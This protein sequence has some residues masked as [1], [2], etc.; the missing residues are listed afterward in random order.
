[1]EN[2]VQK[3]AE[4]LNIAGLS[5]SEKLH[6]LEDSVTRLIDQSN[7]YHKR[8]DE[9]KHL[10]LLQWLSSSPFTR[11]HEAISETRMPN[12][13][14]W[15]LN[16]SRF[17]TWRDSSSSSML[18][19]HGIQGSGKSKICSAVVDAFLN[20]RASN[21][22]TA[23]VAYF[24]CADCEFEPERAEASHVM[25]SIL[26]QLTIMNTSQ[27]TVHDTLLSEFESRLAQS[28]I[29]GMDLRK[30]TV[31]DC[32]SLILEVTIRNPVTI[33]VDALDEVRETERAALTNA[34]EEIVV[35]SSSV[36]K[37]FLTSRNNSHNFSLLG[38]TNAPTQAVASHQ[39]AN[40]HLNEIEINSDATL[41]DMRA[42]VSR[43]LAQAVEYR[44]LLKQNPSLALSDLL[45]EKLLLGAGEMFQWVNA[46]IEYLC[47]H[48]REEDITAALHGGSFTSLGDT[49]MQIL[50]RILGRQTTEREIAV[51]AISWL[52]Y[53]Q[54]PILANDFVTVI[55]AQRTS[56]NAL[57]D[58]QELLTICSSLIQLDTKCNTFRF[59]HNS[60]Q[61]FLRTQEIF[62]PQSAQL[63]LALDCLKVCA[64]GPL[65][66]VEP[67]VNRLYGY[68]AVY[69]AYH[70]SKA[71]KSQDQEVLANEVISFVCDSP[72]DFSLSF[73]EWLNCIESIAK[74]L[75]NQH[76]MTII[77]NALPNHNASPLFVASVFGLDYL[78]SPS[79]LG[80]EPVDWNQKSASGHS[81]LY[82]A[83]AYGNSSV[84][85]M[86]LSCGADPEV[87]SGRLG[88]PL[89]AA[90]FYGHTSAAQLLLEFG[91]SVRSGGTFS[92]ALEACFRGQREA[93]AMALLNH[94]D[95]VQSEEDFHSA[96]ELA[97][98]TGSLEVIEW[99]TS[100]SFSFQNSIQQSEKVQLKTARAIKGGHTG[101][102]RTFLRDKPNPVALLPGGPIAIAAIYGHESVID[103][104]I[105]LHLDLEDECKI[106]SPLRCAALMNRERIMRKLISLGADV[107]GC[108]QHGTA[109]QAASM[110]GHV[111][112]VELLLDNH[113][114]INAG[115]GI[116]GTGLQAAAFYGHHKVTEILLNGGANMRLQGPGKWKD[117]FH[118]AAEGG[119]YNIVKLMIDQGYTPQFPTAGS[120]M[121][122][123]SSVASRLGIPLY[124]AMERDYSLH[125]IFSSIR[126]EADLLT[127][128]DNRYAN[129]QD[130]SK[131]ST[132]ESS[133]RD[134]NCVFEIS[135][136]MG[137]T[138]VVAT[139][140]ESY[141]DLRGWE[142]RPK[143][144]SSLQIAAD[145][146]HTDVF[147]LIFA[148]AQYTI[149]DVFGFLIIAAKNGHWDII[150]FALEKVEVKDWIESG[151]DT[152]VELASLTSQPVVM[153]NFLLVA[154]HISESK[155]EKALN[156][157]IAQAISMSNVQL[158]NVLLRH[159]VRLGKGLGEHL[160]KAARLGNTQVVSQMLQHDD[161]I[162]GRSGR[163]AFR[164]AFLAACDGCHAS[165]VNALL[166]VADEH[167]C[168]ALS[169]EGVLISAWRGHAELLVS[170]AGQLSPTRLE[171]LLPLSLFA[172]A[173][174]GRHH[175]LEAI[176]NMR[177][178]WKGYTKDTARA[179][180][181][182]AFNGHEE[183]IEALIIAGVDTNASSSVKT[184][185]KFGLK[186]EAAVL[187]DNEKARLRQI[188]DVIASDGNQS[189]HGAVA[190]C[191]D[192][193]DES[194]DGIG[195]EHVSGLKDEEFDDCF[196]PLNDEDDECS[197]DYRI[198][199]LQAALAGL[200]HSHHTHCC[201][202]CA[203]WQ[204][205][206]SRC[207]IYEKGTRLINIW[208]ATGPW[209]EG[210]NTNREKAIT[211]LLSHGSDCNALGGLQEPPIIIAS[212]CCSEQVVCWL[213]EAGANVNVIID[214]T[215]AVLATAQ[216]RYPEASI[217]QRLL[218]AGASLYSSSTDDLL[219]GCL[220][221]FPT[222][223]YFVN[224]SD[225]PGRATYPHLEKD[226]LRNAFINGPGAIVQ[227]ILREFALKQI[228]HLD[229]SGFLQAA[230]VLDE[231]A[232]VETLL[233]RHVDVNAVG[234][235]YGTAL[236]AA[237]RFGRVQLVQRLLDLGADPNI[238]K[239]FHGTALRAAVVGNHAA[240][241]E[242][243]LENSADMD[244]GSSCYF[245][246]PPLLNLATE[247]E[248][249]D[250]VSMLVSAGFDL[251]SN[252]QE[253][254]NPLVLAC[255]TGNFEIIKYFLEAGAPAGLLRT[256]RFPWTDY[257]R[258]EV[259]ALHMACHHG[260]PDIIR[261][262]LRF[263]ED[264]D[265]EFVGDVDME[266][267]GDVDMEVENHGSALQVA[268]KDG[269]VIAVRLLL[270]AGARV[271][272]HVGCRESALCLAS[273]NGHLAVVDELLAADA[274]I[275]DPGQ[276]QNALS[277]AC[278]SK[279]ITLVEQLLEAA[280]GTEN[281]TEAILDAYGD[282]IKTDCSDAMLNLLREYIPAGVELQAKVDIAE[283]RPQVDE[284]S[285]YMSELDESDWMYEELK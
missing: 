229:F 194:S 216:R 76:P 78:L 285:E 103:L 17:T 50:K 282:A 269:N 132:R 136:A 235:Y 209:A 55:F 217:L 273:S 242:L 120:C 96:M 143:L 179:M 212:R 177:D 113:A 145:C 45:H 164:S 18:L 79:V 88:N 41:P 170:L 262:L 124:D 190:L 205:L 240:V 152:L 61:E 178:N 39:R 261:L 237:A 4:L 224:F 37:V 245:S 49:Y 153:E 260:N 197:K 221:H 102:L 94:H 16:H 36:V 44:R 163:A 186:V 226:A 275:Y 165:V 253:H 118:C 126:T 246:Q 72:G 241:V 160:A 244:L 82:L 52:L 150:Q 154:E 123:T 263:V 11:H 15:L 58:Q 172:A 268:S 35:K 127:A 140:L 211:H 66:D 200:E 28:K 59:S 131:T 191:Y 147:R 101:T 90:C 128:I 110:K 43:E 283:L 60:V 138:Q 84:A 77:L 104:F 258:H 202:P 24:Y 161:K 175:A 259:S 23:P 100:Q 95:A 63:V 109:L 223:Q 266:F 3:E 234:S 174:N 225:A 26:R 30:V 218:K 193:E 166:E 54:E 21:Q 46:Q 81:A 48:N 64:Q 83:C 207:G 157:G 14:L 213:V 233:Q 70:C 116:Y 167:D 148:V 108:G 231:N 142:W 270:E 125:D 281:G 6:Y 25:R 280:S 139:M 158:L 20:E 57:R 137:R 151:F 33:I 106:G 228:G 214:G 248:N 220:E 168:L 239:G 115:S 254:M 10:E 2:I 159:Y 40:L 99:L 192:E 9:T 156:C 130:C 279:S 181:I 114:Q 267:V 250:I 169:S 42:Y 93:T 176:L 34:L 38:K 87:K 251:W 85:R 91:T 184:F 232:C 119:N 27:S 206:L 272:H 252:S 117:A 1:M 196:G 171:T 201:D 122:S 74:D 274:A 173:G 162:N 227:T 198:N 255:K 144:L 71:M 185:I 134:E 62:S 203:Q 146:G 284:Y 210:T 135:A 249:I 271:N 111:R 51:R 107:N 182:A 215:D 105:N 13:A 195:D 129:N 97:C 256:P 75:P 188:L 86:L 98:E 204:H 89:Q 32:V 219:N 7:V 29:D 183:I 264:V 133:D 56:S 189:S 238:L 265:M 230:I 68:T 19:L 5:D 22:F 155:N 69:W 141:S 149:K 187:K 53:M 67:A 65:L 80:V 8:L 112:I 208:R 92:K 121:E 199:A 47:Q 257:A 222:D 73:L 247:T 278:R 31:K 12:S 243:L 276:G 236:Q 277:S 180:I